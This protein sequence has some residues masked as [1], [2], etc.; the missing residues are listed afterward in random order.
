MAGT[1][2]S[3]VQGASGRRSSLITSSAENR[4]RIRAVAPTAVTASAPTMWPR[5]WWR[6]SGQSSRSS[7]DIPMTPANPAA[8]GHR[9]LRWLEST[10]F[11]R[12]V[13]P[14]V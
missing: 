11:G 13:D 10:P 12:P 7:A 14:D 5:A 4:G 1:A 9:R 8:T 3:S 6:G 2:A